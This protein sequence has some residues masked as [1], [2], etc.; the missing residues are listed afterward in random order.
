MTHSRWK[1]YCTFEWN[2]RV[3]RLITQKPYLSGQVRV[4]YAILNQ[5]TSALAWNPYCPFQIHQRCL[6]GQLSESYAI[7]N[8]VARLLA[9]HL[10]IHLRNIRNQSFIYIY[11]RLCHFFLYLSHFSLIYS[12]LFYLEFNYFNLFNFEI[13]FE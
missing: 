10:V 11:Q 8:L 2:M 5:D 12:Y 4:N 6:F 9:S 1:I 13:T 7:L 3:G